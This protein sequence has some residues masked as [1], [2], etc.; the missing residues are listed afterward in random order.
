VERDYVLNPNVPLSEK[1]WGVTHE[2]LEDIGL[3]A[4]PLRLSFLN[5][6]DL[7]YDRSKIGTKTC[8]AMVCAVGVSGSPAVMTH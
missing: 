5:P 4:E 6:S 7:G 8:S 1:T 2:I 3:G